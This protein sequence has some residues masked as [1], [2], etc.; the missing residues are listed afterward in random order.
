MEGALVLIRPPDVIAAEINHLKRQTEITVM[1]NAI[2]IGRRLV[3]AKERVP[4]GEWGNWLE[5]AVEFKQ[6][7]ANNLM[8]IFAEYAD[9]QMSLFVEENAKSQTFANLTY[10]KAVALLAV[11]ADER[12]DFVKE[13]D[14]ESMSTRDLKAVIKERDKALKELAQAKKLAEKKEAELRQITEEKKKSDDT[15]AE[16]KE[17]LQ[18]TTGLLSSANDDI[19]A[20]Q[21]QLKD[22]PIDVTA[23]AV[24]EKIPDDIA[25]ELEELRNKQRSSEASQVLALSNSMAKIF[26]SILE[27]LAGI[28]DPAEQNKYKKA[29]LA[30]LDEMSVRLN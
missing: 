1:N 29:L 3:E 7:T 17:E 21:K 28:A 8:R 26:Q 25:Q 27:L 18:D 4:H 13:N 6:S 5:T 20:L 19:E 2:E 16:L 11:P 9:Q 15:V 30:L 24:A 12:E 10:T 14:V 22:T 23:N